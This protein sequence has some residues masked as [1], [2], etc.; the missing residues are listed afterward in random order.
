MQVFFFNVRKYKVIPFEYFFLKK[1]SKKN[2]T[3]NKNK[4]T[5]KAITNVE[6]SSG[7]VDSIF[8]KQLSPGVGWGHN[9][10]SKFYIVIHRD[11]Y[12]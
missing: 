1:N 7:K 12:L 5:N 3:K 11:N 10:R 6:S 2:P 9:V 4:L 8:F